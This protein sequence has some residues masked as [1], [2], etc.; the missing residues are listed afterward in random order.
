MSKDV[1]RE[2]HQG[3]SNELSS[4]CLKFTLSASLVMLDATDA[5][6]STIS[7]SRFI[8]ALADVT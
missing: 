5:A 8:I 6:I 7:L 4:L 1:Y 3:M 2:A